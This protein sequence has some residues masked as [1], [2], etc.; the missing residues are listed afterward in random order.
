MSSK[1]PNG[2]AHSSSSIKASNNHTSFQT[3]PLLCPLPFKPS[4]YSV[5]FL[6]NPPSTLSHSFHTIFHNLSSYFP[7]IYL[8]YPL[9]LQSSYS[10]LSFSSYTKYPFPP[11][12]IYSPP[13]QA[14]P[15]LCTN[16]SVKFTQ[17]LQNTSY[18]L[19]L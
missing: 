12:D 7:T 15:L 19:Y 13:F 14:L 4:L 11:T 6:L 5:P 2:V 17:N 9:T 3:L 1:I 16:F 8:F 18:V 10:T